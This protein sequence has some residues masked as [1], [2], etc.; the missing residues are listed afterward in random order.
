MLIYF[1]QSTI[2]FKIH[3]SVC[4]FQGTVIA[5]KNPDSWKWGTDLSRWAWVKFQGIS[6]LIIQGGGTIDGQG[7][8]WWNQYS[9]D[10]EEDG[11]KKPTVSPRKTC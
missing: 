5:P 8:S 2:R 7:S 1:V 11:P 3:Y 9:K 4:Q 10:E 6:N